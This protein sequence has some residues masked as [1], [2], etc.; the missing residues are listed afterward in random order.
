M[1]HFDTEGKDVYVG[2]VTHPLYTISY[3]SRAIVSNKKTS[4]LTTLHWNFGILWTI[5]NANII[6]IGLRTV[7]HEAYK[8]WMWDTV[9]GHDVVEVLPEEHL[10]IFILRLEITTW[11]GHDPLI[12]LIV[13]MSGHG[14]PFDV[15]AHHPR[16]L[17]VP[18]RLHA[19]NQIHSTSRT[20]LGHLEDEN[21]GCIVTLSWELIPL[22]VGPIANA[23][24][25]CDAIH[26]TKPPQIFERGNL[27]AKVWGIELS[28]ALKH[29]FKLF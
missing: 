26:N 16:V 9:S 21:L 1:T 7:R 14:G 10:G 22:D 8:A 13:D 18:T 28:T 3:V 19:S 24:E 11:N 27:R 4:A 5:H 6:P 20:N 12:S 17:N 15:I 25:L 23:L 2:L 29:R